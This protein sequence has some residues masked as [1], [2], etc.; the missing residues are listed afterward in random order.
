MDGASKSASDSKVTNTSGNQSMQ[1]IPSG[2]EALTIAGA[3][4]NS[5]NKRRDRRLLSSLLCGDEKLAETLIQSGADVNYSN[6][7]GMTPLMAAASRG[8]PKMITLRAK[9][10][11]KDK[12]NNQALHL[13]AH[14]TSYQSS[15]EIL[16][17]EGANVNSRNDKGETPLIVAAKADCKLHYKRER[18]EHVKAAITLIEA[19]VDVN[20]GAT[21]G[22]TTLIITA[23][24]GR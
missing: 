19:G 6:K 21:D 20:T 7:N 9:V 10:N 3:D 24:M 17:E 8:L 2:E 1:N 11:S 18:A 13:V 23:K 12:E 14:L 16:L 22:T 5:T 15:L 4:V